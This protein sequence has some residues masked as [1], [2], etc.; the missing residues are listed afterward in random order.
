M[1][2]RWSLEQFRSKMK[3]QKVD[4]ALPL[5]LTYSSAK[6][7]GNNVTL[8]TNVSNMTTAVCTGILQSLVFGLEIGQTAAKSTLYEAPLIIFGPNPTHTHTLVSGLW[9]C[10][11]SVMGAITNCGAYLRQR[12]KESGKQNKHKH[13]FSGAGE[14]RGEK[15]VQV[16]NKK[17]NG[18]H[19]GTHAHI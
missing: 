14:I 1:V 8:Q 3:Q 4:P 19:A 5:Y 11:N 2:C 13:L 10:K 7:A 17:H 15:M 18:T 9:M 16:K 12:M 6:T